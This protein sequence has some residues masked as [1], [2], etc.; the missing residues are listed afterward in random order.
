MNDIWRCC[1]E[2]VTNL[3]DSERNSR[4]FLAMTPWSIKASGW[5]MLQEIAFYG[6]FKE[7]Y[8]IKCA[9]YHAEFYR[10]IQLF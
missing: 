3:Y 2:L 4:L 6:T 10:K 7:L 8:G 1:S 5:D 9:R